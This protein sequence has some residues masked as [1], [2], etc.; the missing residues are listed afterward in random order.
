MRVGFTKREVAGA[1]RC[2]LFASWHRA[3]PVPSSFWQ[4]FVMGPRR[5]YGLTVLSERLA[6][7]AAADL[8]WPPGRVLVLPG[9]VDV[10]RFAPRERSPALAQALG[11]RPGEHVVGVVARLQP[12]RRF[13]LLLEAFARA[14]QEAPELRLLVVGRGTRAQSVLE[15]PLARLGL[16]DAV[17]RAG[18]RSEDFRDVLAW[19]DA[20]VF[21]VPGSDGSCRAVLEA[22]AMGIP[23]IA[24]QRGILPELVV[25]GETG[26]VVPEDAAALANSFVDVAREPARWRVRGTAARLRALQRHP[27]E[28][29]AQQLEQFYASLQV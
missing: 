21:L 22:M 12:H 20:L 7:A 10:K 28:Q 2:A 15:E 29:H 24:S 13:D 11:I 27:V 23:V 3:E 5:L 19:L 8:G 16:G 9:V 25:S 17:I 4:R 18:Y 6:R 1:P 14:R 26:L